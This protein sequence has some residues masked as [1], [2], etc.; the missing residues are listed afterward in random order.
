MYLVLESLLV[1]GCLAGLLTILGAVAA[2]RERL[3]TSGVRAKFGSWEVV[4]SLLIFGLMAG[5]RWNVG[6]DHMIYRGWYQFAEQHGYSPR[7]IEVGFQTVM[8][9][10]ARVG[11]HYSVFF[12]LIAFCQVY[13]VYKAFKN[14][15]Y[16]LPFLALVLVLG[17]SYLTWMN[18]MRQMIVA[19]VFLYSIQF[20]YDRKWLQ[21]FGVMLAA[22]LVHKTAFL[23]L[24]L[25]FLPVKDYFHSRVVVLVSIPIT[26]V[27]GMNDTFLNSISTAFIFLADLLGYQGYSENV[28]SFLEAGQQRNFGP[29]TWAL[30]MS[31]ALVVWYSPALKKRF[32]ATH[33][34]M[35][36][37]LGV[38]GLLLYNL[39]ANAHHI[40]LRPVSYLMFFYM[41]LSAYLLLYL[42]ER[43]RKKAIQFFVALCFTCAYTPLSVVADYSMGDK[44][45][46]LY[47]VFWLYDP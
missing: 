16:L 40:F 30:I 28:D 25:Y 41:P 11:V 10:M 12:G 24:P 2:K 3:F 18:L 36:Y 17:S 45:F 6:V 23:L 4:F 19:G 22:S 33:F 37:N 31:M 35:F 43:S 32:S 44:S 39:L 5:M 15:R 1:Y 29:R 20:I 7:S 27:V 14:E 46:V 34:L 9:L 42:F 38:A 13:F 47:K 8:E 21:F 26:I